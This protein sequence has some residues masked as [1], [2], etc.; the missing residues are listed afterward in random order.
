MREI[1][2]TVVPKFNPHSTDEISQCMA[3]ALSEGRNESR[4]QRGFA[5][6][7]EFDWSRT[8]RQTLDLYEKVAGL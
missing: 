8:A 1:Y 6:A 2:G 4:R 7:A 5:Y 3:K